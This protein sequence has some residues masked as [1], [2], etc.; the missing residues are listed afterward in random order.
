MPPK[1]T[2]KPLEA[3]ALKKAIEKH[4]PRVRKILPKEIIE[5][6]GKGAYTPIEK[7]SAREVK[8]REKVEMSKFEQDMWLIGSTRKKVEHRKPIRHIWTL[9]KAM[10]GTENRPQNYVPGESRELPIIPATRREFIPRP[11]KKAGPKNRITPEKV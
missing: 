6:H 5:Q 2:P 11:L 7:A 9:T 10:R 8:R 1:R 4:G 3:L